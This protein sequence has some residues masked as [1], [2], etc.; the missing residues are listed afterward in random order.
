MPT[1]NEIYKT[2]GDIWWDENHVLSMLR[3][4]LNPVRFGYFR[5]VLIEELGADLRGTTALDI[6]CGGGLLAEEFARLG[7]NVTGIDPSEPALEIARAHAAGS[8][9]KIEY[10]H[11]RG[12]KIPFPDGSFDIA[13]CCDVLEHVDNV[14]R[15]IGETARV[16]KPG[17]IYLYDTLNRTPLS[18]LVMIKIAQDWKVTRFVETRL[19]DWAMFIKPAELRHLMARHGIES[20][21]IAG[22]EPGISPLGMMTLSHKRKRGEITYGELGRRGA[23]RRTRRTWVSYM[24]CGVVRR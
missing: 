8:G 10:R 3:T 18:K 9:L 12:E 14:D 11:G 20:R 15:V 7:L 6:G 1:D 24:G 21:G 2:P 17:G 19:H 5:E 23:F 16:L 22:I 13:Y 4:A